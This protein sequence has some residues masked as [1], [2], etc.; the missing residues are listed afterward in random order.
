MIKTLYFELSMGI[1]EGQDPHAFEFSYGV[2]RYYDGAVLRIH[3]NSGV[4]FAELPKWITL[5]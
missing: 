3:Y 5:A 4:K 2:E 1:V